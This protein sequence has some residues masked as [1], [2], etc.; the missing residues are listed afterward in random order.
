VEAGVI[1]QALDFVR[2]NIEVSAWIEDGGRRQERWD[3]P[4]DAVREAIV[5]AVAHR[6]YTITFSDIELSI[7]ADRL[8]V[9]LARASPQHGDG[10]E[11][12]RGLP[13]LAQ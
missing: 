12:A 2:R 9:I 11:N 8:E 3:Y 1:E 4:L 10:R 5:N 6:A 13:C 7:Y